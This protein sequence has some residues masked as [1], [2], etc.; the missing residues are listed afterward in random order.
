MQQTFCGH[1]GP[2]EVADW[3]VDVD[4]QTFRWLLNISVLDL[5]KV[6]F[7]TALYFILLYDVVNLIAAQSR[8]PVAL[9]DW[10]APL[11]WML[12]VFADE[13]GWYASSLTC[14][15]VNILAD[16]REHIAC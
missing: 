11:K 9:M 14:M 10:W 4:T 13:Y 16:G 1:Y 7:D 3:C 15:D 6:F 8:Q 5:G 12:T 2:R